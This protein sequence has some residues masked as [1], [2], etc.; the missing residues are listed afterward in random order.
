MLLI[1]GF[2]LLLSG[3]KQAASAQMPREGARQVISVA[4]L[5]EI[6]ETAKSKS[7]G[8]AANEIGHLD[9]S[10][11]L[12]SEQLARL[13]EELPGANSKAALM[14][15]GDASVFLEPP[16][17]DLLDTPAPDLAEQQR[18]ISRAEDYLR[19]IIPKLPDF[20]ARRTTTG[21]KEVWTAKDRKGTHPPGALQRTGVSQDNVLYRNG[22]EIVRAENDGARGLETRGTFG[23]VLSAV[24]RDNL[25]SPMKWHGWEKGP[26]GTMAIFEFQ[27]SQKES[28]YEVSFNTIFMGGSGIWITGRVTGYRGEIGI[29]P[30]TG[31]ILRLVLLSDPVLGFRFIG[32]A[33]VMLE[34]GPVLIGGKAYTC[35]VRSVSMSTATYQQKGIVRQDGALIL[36][37]DVVF[38]GYHIFRSEMR[39]LPN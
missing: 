38:T 10:E 4:Q 15:V 6:V 3:S 39:I 31:T 8:I 13:S 1:I 25:H 27:V 23:P 30:D 35:P 36:L 37:E 21:F 29:D 28:H 34:Y 32:H 33:N 17:S 2:V 5:N 11:R 16:Q 19:T 26:N 7:D 9:L 24:I 14:A 22:K 20:L 12:S 18:I